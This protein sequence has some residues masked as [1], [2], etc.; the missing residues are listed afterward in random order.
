MKGQWFIISA[1]FAAFAIF[2]VSSDLRSFSEIDTAEAAFYNEDY[3]FA[4]LRNDLQRTIALSGNTC[5]ELARS[6]NEYI[7]FSQLSKGRLGYSVNVTYAI[8]D[9]ASKRVRFNLII[10]QSEKLQVWE[11]IRS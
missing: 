8:E 5:A 2:A 7:Y 3:H 9:C 11:G 10:L 1:I 4:N 6:L